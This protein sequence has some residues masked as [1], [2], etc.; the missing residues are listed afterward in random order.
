MEIVLA[1]VFSAAGDSLDIG[2]SLGSLEDMECEMPSKSQ[3]EALITS[4]ETALLPE[5]KA[6]HS[7]F[8]TWNSAFQTH[9]LSRFLLQNT[10][11]NSEC[12]HLLA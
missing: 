7:T 9:T 10:H 8:K 4:S 2:S 1:L 11:C 12:C 6:V 5:G 3:P